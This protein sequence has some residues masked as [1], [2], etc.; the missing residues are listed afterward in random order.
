MTTAL[1]QPLTDFF[2]AV[3]AVD[4]EAVGDCLAEEVT[5]QFLVP[6]PAA[7]GRK[8]VIDALRSSLTAADRI[9]WEPTSHLAGDDLA[10]VER[11]DRFWFGEHEAAIDVVGVF[12]LADGRITAVRDYADLNTWRERKAAALAA[13]RNADEGAS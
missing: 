11:V 7:V 12:E 9:S 6:H 4:L 2:A 8:A 5:Y 1:P 3:N 13:G 10:F